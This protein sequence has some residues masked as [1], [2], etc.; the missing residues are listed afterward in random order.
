MRN[1]TYEPGLEGPSGYTTFEHLIIGWMGSCVPLK[2]DEL[3]VVD[4]NS[5]LES[6]T[7]ASSIEAVVSVILIT[8][9][10]R[11]LC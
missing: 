5:L 3:G 1:L 7:I 10:V 9:R 11:F 4:V 2:S 8:T 6:D